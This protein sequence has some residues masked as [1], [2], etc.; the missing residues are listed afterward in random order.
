MIGGLLSSLSG[1]CRY[2]V[3]HVRC[4]GGEGDRRWVLF[5]TPMLV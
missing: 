5:Y 3:L 1:D 4:S 2:I